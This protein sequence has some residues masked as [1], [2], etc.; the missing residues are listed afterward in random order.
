MSSL[1]FIPEKEVVYMW[2]LITYFPLCRWI[3]SFY[4]G[5]DVRQEDIKARFEDGTL[6]LQVPKNM[7]EAVPE[8][9][10]YIAIEG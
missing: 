4:V 6:K 8:K 5:E 2:N 3:R 9:S 7:K 10:N 1:F